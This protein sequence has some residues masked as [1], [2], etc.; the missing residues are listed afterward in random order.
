MQGSVSQ[1]VYLCPSLNFIKCRKSFMKKTAKSFLFFVP[2]SI[3]SVHIL[4]MS[5]NFIE[6]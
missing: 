5:F 3:P 4:K 2:A 6:K 1:I